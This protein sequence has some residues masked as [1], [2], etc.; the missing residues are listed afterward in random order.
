MIEQEDDDSCIYVYSYPTSNFDDEVIVFV[1]RDINENVDYAFM[2][3]QTKV[4]N[5][6]PLRNA[7]YGQLD[8]NSQRTPY[9]QWDIYVCLGCAKKLI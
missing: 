3:I 9:G 2:S 6:T 7:P 1:F 8:S 5:T 4:T